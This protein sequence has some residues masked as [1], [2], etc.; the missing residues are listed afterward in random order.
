MGTTIKR[1][2]DTGEQ[3]NGGQFGSTRRGDA[4]VQVSEPGAATPQQ[5]G[6]E[7][8]AEDVQFARRLTG[9]PQ[10]DSVRGYYAAMDRIFDAA[11][12]FVENHGSHE[13]DPAP[14]VDG[15]PDHD[16]LAARKA[17]FEAA[18]TYGDTFYGDQCQR[19]ARARALAAADIYR[20]AAQEDTSEA[21]DGLRGLGARH[22]AAY[23]SF[24]GNDDFGDTSMLSAYPVFYDA[25]GEEMEW[26]EEPEI[27]NGPEYDDW[28]MA[29]RDEWIVQD[30]APVAREDP[31]LESM[32]TRTDHAYVYRCSP[33]PQSA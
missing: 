25:D 27:Q 21:I 32:T 15:G 5:V 23:V 3:G 10:A 2:K 6:L 26:H 24:P 8:L 1:K 19:P 33:S 29:D 16:G 12:A 14:P 20:S 31:E 30:L 4:E 9:T 11:D 7:Q 22:G 13:P 17:A 28:I 18:R